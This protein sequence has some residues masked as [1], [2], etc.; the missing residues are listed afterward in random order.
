M[1]LLHWVW[2]GLAV[3]PGSSLADIILRRFPDP[4]EFFLAGQPGIDEVG[5][6]AGYDELRI[7]ATTLDMAKKAIE[8]VENYGAKAVARNSEF[9]PK[10]LLKIDDCPPVLYVLGD[11]KCLNKMPAIGVVGTRRISDYGR[12]MSEIIAGGLGAAGA[13]VVS[14]MAQG[15]DTAAH[16]ACLAAGGKTIAVQ[17]CGICNT[18]P[19]E[20]VELKELIA[21]NGAVVSEFAPDAEPQSSF[22]LI[23]NRIVSGMSLGICVVEAAAR[24]GTSVT[25]NLAIEQGRRVFAVPADVSRPTSQGTLRLLKKGATPVANAMDILSEYSNE[26]KEEIDFSRLGKNYKKFISPTVNA[27]SPPN[28]PA[29]PLKKPLPNGISEKAATLYEFIDSVPRF[30]DELSNM[31]GLSASETAAALTELEIFSLIKPVAGRKFVIL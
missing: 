16:K 18:Y 22:F 12:K 24:S 8:R 19:S 7:R 14:G 4:E 31:A 29:K 6:I 27:A 26:Y 20:N 15:V 23:R 30:V 17:G 13:V 3:Q 11:E 28:E 2:L 1:S 21:A 9:F 25:A 5:C 10:Q